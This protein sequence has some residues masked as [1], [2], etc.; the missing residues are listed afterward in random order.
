MQIRAADT[1]LTCTNAWE[2]HGVKNKLLENNF[3][4][5]ENHGK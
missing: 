1:R 4:F 2:S 5:L 3:I